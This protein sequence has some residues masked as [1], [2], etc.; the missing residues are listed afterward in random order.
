MSPAA[1]QP[2][3]EPGAQAKLMVIH[4]LGL[5]PV[6][7][8]QQVARPDRRP[9]RFLKEDAQSPVFLMGRHQLLNH[10]S[11]PRKV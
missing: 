10:W 4:N 7:A 2:R 8:G 3:S 6:D 11:H 9:S 5:T 1:D